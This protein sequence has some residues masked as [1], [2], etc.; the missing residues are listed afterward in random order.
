MLKEITCSICTIALMPSRRSYGKTPSH[1][2]A[3]NTLH[4]WRN[5]RRCTKRPSLQPA[6]AH[7]CPSAERCAPSPLDAAEAASG[8]K[9]R[10]FVPMARAHVAP[11]VRRMS[12]Q[13]AR[14]R[15]RATGR[16]RH[17]TRGCGGCNRRGSRAGM[18]RTGDERKERQQK[19][20]Q[21]VKFLG[22]A[23]EKD[24]VAGTNA[25]T[26]IA[27]RIRRSATGTTR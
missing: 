15:V 22:A 9:R 20:N 11:P 8:A 24:N 27:G 14:K 5:F 17:R 2:P 6:R 1:E 25:I 7:R 13:L 3:R 23:S 12:C 4:G 21:H 16:L 18:D 10:R 26:A 19:R